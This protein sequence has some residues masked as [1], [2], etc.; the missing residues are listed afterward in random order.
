MLT[1]QQPHYAPSDGTPRAQ[2]ATRVPRSR[3]LV[4]TGIVVVLVAIVAGAIWGATRSH[5]GGTTTARATP[6]ATATTIPHVIYQ[7][8]WS[9]GAD[10]WTLPAQATIVDGHLLLDSKTPISLQIPYI[11]T[12]PTYAIDM[13]FQIEAVTPG[14]YFGLTT[15][16]AAGDSQYAAQMMCTP[17]HEGA[18]TPAMGGCPGAVLVT[19]R[20]GRDPSQLFT[21]DYVIGPGTQTFHLEVTS[22]TV[23]FCPVNDCLV[24]VTSAQPL[25]ASP[26]IFI[27]DRAVKLLITRVTLTTF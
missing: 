4:I 15:R 8:D 27:E 2:Q 25:D 22:D 20:G 19:I 26:H 13:E 12:T 7:A 18:W 1:D 9:H 23:N 11:P 24:P 5:A 10:G 17:M 21:S 14:G 16:N 6:S 3:P